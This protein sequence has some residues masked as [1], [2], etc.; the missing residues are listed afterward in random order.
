MFCRFCGSNLSNDSTFCHSCG[1]SPTTSAP[2]EQELTMF[3][4][5]LNPATG[6]DKLKHYG[7]IGFLVFLVVEEAL[8]HL[9]PSAAGNT[10]A[11][12]AF[13]LLFVLP[14]LMSKVPA[15]S[16]LRKPLFALSW[17]YFW[18]ALLYFFHWTGL[19]RVPRGYDAITDLVSTAGFVVA[20]WMITEHEADQQGKSAERASLAI[21]C[22][23]LVVSS[24]SKLL[25]DI[26]GGHD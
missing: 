12:F 23:L 20:W 26:R 14:P 8:K 21:L 11:C 22:L 3:K 15:E 16:T 13:G 7:F 18:M 9:E 4:W 24:C 25:I 19:V 5:L 10:L 1:K 6:L 2:G 17:A